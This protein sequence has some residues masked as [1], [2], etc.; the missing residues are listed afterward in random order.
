MN[1]YL[2]DGKWVLGD[3]PG[4]GY[5]KVSK[6]Q[7]RLL[8]RIIEKFLLAK[9]FR[10]AVQVIDARHPGLESDLQ[11]QDWLK[12]EGLPFLIVMNKVDKLNRKQRAEVQE[13]AKK[14]FVHQPFLFVSTKTKEGKKELQGMLHK[15]G[16]FAAANVRSRSEL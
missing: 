10:F 6:E 14:M 1:L 13:Q 4:Y 12:A 15:V 16:T 3:F 7:R 8:E 2:V 5:A 9:Y 11:V